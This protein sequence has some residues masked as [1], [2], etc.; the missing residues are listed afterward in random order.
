MRR[1]NAKK[2]ERRHD[3]SFLRKASLGCV[4]ALISFGASAKNSTQIGT[5]SCNVSQGAG[6]VVVQKQ[7]LSCAFKNSRSG[8][9]EKYAGRI[10]QFGLALGEVK[11]GSLVWGVLAATGSPRA[12]ALAGTYTGVGANASI[13]VGAGANILVGGSGRAF[14]L[15]PLSVQGQRGVNIAGGVTT[16]TLKRAK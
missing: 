10:D 16:V 1:T 13:G 15:Q 5:L 2:K 14:S 11:S 12:G 8:K 3:M 4:V 7:T 9:V 6:M